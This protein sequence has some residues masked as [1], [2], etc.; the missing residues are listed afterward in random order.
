MLEPFLSP[1]KLM[2]KPFKYATR[3]YERGEAESRLYRDH[4]K[5]IQNRMCMRHK[6][7]SLYPPNLQPLLQPGVRRLQRSA[8]GTPHDNLDYNL[9]SISTLFTIHRSKHSNKAKKGCRPNGIG[10]WSAKRSR[11]A[12]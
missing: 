11:E 5:E 12:G 4:Y 9:A 8:D 2:L 1:P 3:D 10:R 7:P 6:F